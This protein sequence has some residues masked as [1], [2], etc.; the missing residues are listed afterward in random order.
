[1]KNKNLH[2]HLDAILFDLDGTLLDTAPDLYA[3][4]LL[5]LKQLGYKPVSFD[6]FRP[7][8]HTG[9]ASML[10]GSL[11]IE[12]QD[13]IF[14]E[15]CT[16]F[17]KHY[18]N[19]IHHKTDYF[20]GMSD[21]L[22][23]LDRLQ[24]PWGIVTNKPAF[25]TEPLIASFQLNKRTKCIVSGDT[26]SNKKPHPAPLI[27]ACALIKAT[28]NKSIYVGDTQSDVQAAKAASLFSIA[29]CYGYHDPNDTPPESWG[30]DLLVEKPQQILHMLNLMN[31]TK[32]P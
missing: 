2:N 10:K 26:L 23:Q 25:L 27:H 30:A 31:E 16:I 9:T 8:I 12:E 32:N 21:V 4:M 19:L 29:V 5:T 7:H 22:D 14:S 13:P 20:P 11:N 1:M 6:D 15:I 18:A 28:P 24:I 3:A 17:L